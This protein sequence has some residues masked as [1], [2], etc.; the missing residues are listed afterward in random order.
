[1]A[2]DSSGSASRTRLV[3]LCVAAGLTVMLGASLARV[4]QLQVRPSV[5]LQEQMTP[6]VTAREDLA[7]RGDV[8]D[9]RGRL[10]AST[11]VSRRV[12]LDPTIFQ[13]NENLDEATQRLAAAMGVPMAT[14]RERLTWAFSENANREVL[15]ANWPAH[16]EQLRLAEAEKKAN[17]EATI[18]P[19]TIAR[20]AAKSE[21]IKPSEKRDGELPALSPNDPFAAIVNA[22]LPQIDPTTGKAIDPNAPKEDPKPPKPI[23]Y[24][25]VG[26]ILT[27]EQ[28]ERVRGLTVKSKDKTAPKPL[29]GVVLE[30]VPEREFVAGD[31][32]AAIVGKV[33]FGDEGLVGAEYRLN[34][35]L[36]GEAGKISYVRDRTGRPLWIEAGFIVPAAHG[37]SMR[38]SIDLEIQRIVYDELTKQV[39]KTNAAG[40]RV[41]VV[42]PATGELLAIADV[43]RDVPNAVAFPWVPVDEKGKRLG[44]ATFD[45]DARYLWLRPDDGRKIHP[46][47]GRNRAV[48]DVYE[49]GSTFKPF[50]WATITELG[51]IKPDKMI[52]TEGGHWRAPDNRPLSDVVERDQQTWSEVLVNS[53]NIGMVKGAQ[54]LSYKQTHDMLTRFG[55][56]E[57]TN[58]GLP[59]EAAGII[60]SL[61]Q[62]KLYT[63]VSVSYGHNIAVTPVQMARAF[64]VFAREGIHAGTLPQL[65]LTALGSDEAAPVTYR[66][67]PPDTA[68][69]TRQ[70]MGAVVESVERRWMKDE[71]PEGGRRYTLFGKSGTALIPLG[72]PP[73]GFAYP[74]GTK[75]YL[76]NQFISSF[77]AGGP[78]ESPQLVCVAIID[79]PGPQAGQSR[80]ARYGS[81]AAGPLAVRVLERSLTYLGA[82][83]SPKSNVPEAVASKT[84]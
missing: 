23:R 41:V 62:W 75:G 6:R 68:R 54:L 49:P 28:V 44:D 3:A 11:K 20:D 56:G 52:D 16:L 29:R 21:A 26:E 66:V 18:E 8:L 27:D 53:S 15:A 59:G 51:L 80:R 57:R 45:E 36:K 55:F 32:V 61:Q 35:E 42:D 60:P 83:A 46:A 5:A 17:P 30:R 50:V 78:V 12:I 72:A 4:A 64:S 47:L 38:L 69:M 67:L 25:T 76:Q 31:E 70:I 1:M 33:G 22:S 77:V 24:L 39:E 10:L 7:L 9:R 71:I 37:Q 14:V 2:T 48:E 81:A 74:R 58:V 34:D 73:K 79:D 40:G 19:V 63:Q 65:R 13:T 82:P 43:I 84:R